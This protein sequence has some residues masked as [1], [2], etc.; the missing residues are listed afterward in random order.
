MG[1]SKNLQGIFMEFERIFERNFKNL[2]RI[3]NEF[4]IE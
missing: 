1:I 3:L 2:K 4:K